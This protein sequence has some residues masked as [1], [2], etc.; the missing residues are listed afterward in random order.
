VESRWTWERTVA[1]YD[2]LLDGIAR[3]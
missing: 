3:L 2:S 1:G